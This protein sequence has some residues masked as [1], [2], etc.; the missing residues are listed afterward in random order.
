[1]ER[2]HAI[3]QGKK[4]IM[5][6]LK[7][8]TIRMIFAFLI[9]ALCHAPSIRAAVLGCSANGLTPVF[10][11]DYGTSLGAETWHVIDGDPLKVAVGSLGGIAAWT[12]Q[13][14]GITRQYFGEAAWTTHVWVDGTNALKM[15]NGKYLGG[16][17][18]FSAGA[19]HTQTVNG[20]TTTIETFLVLGADA[21]LKQIVTYTE[22]D[23]FYKIRWELTNN[24]G[25]AFS[26]IRLFH[27]GDAYF[28]GV[29]SARSWWDSVQGKIYVNNNDFTNAGIMGFFGS[30]ATPASHYFG[31]N[32]STGNS[33]ANQI[34]RLSDT[35]DSNFVDAGYQLEWDKASLANGATW[36]IE[37]YQVWTDPTPV[38][39]LAP[40]S[41]LSEDNTIISLEFGV[42]N[43]DSSQRTFNLSALSNLGWTIDLPGGSLVTIDALTSVAVQVDVTIPDGLATDTVSTISLT[44]SDATGNGT[45]ATT[46]T[47]FSPDY[48][49]IPSALN[50]GNVSVGDSSTNTITLNNSGSDVVV[51]TVGH[52]NGLALPFSISA[53]NCSGMTIGNGASCTIDVTFDP[54][55]SISSNDTF[56]I[57]ILSPLVISRTIPVSGTGTSPQ[58]TN[59]RLLPIGLKGKGL[60]WVYFE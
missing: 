31:G 26:D 8:N 9:M 27:G 45:S 18:D 56:N 1:M 38:Q 44:A 33:Q 55:S 21:Q 16:G 42:H 32:Y 24:S 11:T 40:A 51:G 37:A 59:P 28:G 53:D 52:P 39:V 34:A 49:I 60:I 19:S 43:L 54:S 7:T 14:N 4:L 5:N 57:P 46:V 20:S 2:T 35:A 30:Q 47:I 15:Y 58:I 10:G 12:C 25:G 6:T 36:V 29:D 13:P 41:Q 23:Y 17:T 3:N 48:E 50:F 22:G